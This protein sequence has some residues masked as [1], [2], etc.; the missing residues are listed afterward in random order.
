MPPELAAACGLTAREVFHFVTGWVLEGKVE[1][2]GASS[3]RGTSVATR[4]EATDADYVD[5]SDVMEELEA[6]GTDADND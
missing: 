6:S 5:F 3:I 2:A 1:I 4:G